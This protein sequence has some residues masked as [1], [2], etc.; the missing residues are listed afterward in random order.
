MLFTP[1]FAIEYEDLR[2]FKAPA[3]RLGTTDEVE[4][5]SKLYKETIEDKTAK[6]IDAYNDIEKLTYADLSIKKISKEISQE[7]NIDYAEMTADLSI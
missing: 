4:V 5:P 7:L 2:D 1:S 6:E 3:Y